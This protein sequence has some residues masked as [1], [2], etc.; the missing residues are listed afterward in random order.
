VT[1][2]RSP[3]IRSLVI[4]EPSALRSSSTSAETE[5][6]RLAIARNLLVAG[7]AVNAGG[8]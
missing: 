2:L 8:G 7:G 4:A 1:P 6:F 3:A 5:T